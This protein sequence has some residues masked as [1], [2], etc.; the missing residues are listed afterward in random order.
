MA[1][2]ISRRQLLIASSIAGLGLS[3]AACTPGSSSGPAPTRSPGAQGTGDPARRGSSTTPLT[4]SGELKESPLLAEQ[5]AAGQLPPVAERVPANPYVVP[6]NWLDE[7]NYGGTIQYSLISGDGSVPPGVA[8]LFY[9]HSMLRYLNDANDIGPGLVESWEV[10]ADATVWTFHLRPGLRW[11]DGAPATTEDIM[12]WWEDLVLNEEHPDS[13]PDETKSSRGTTGTIET[14]SATTFTI[15]FDAP[16]PLTADRMAM[17]TNGPGGQGAMWICP[18]HYLQQFHRT[19]NPAVGAN[20]GLAE[21]LFAQK[22]DLKSNPELPTLN[23]FKVASVQQGQSMVWERNPYY[24]AIT[25]QG[26]QLPFVDR[27]QMTLFQD[28]AVAK[29]Q[30][31]QGKFD[32]GHDHVLANAAQLFE[33][34][35][36]VELE[37]Y[38]WDTGSGTGT[39]IFHN[40]DYEEPKMRR[41]INEP[42]YRQALSLAYNRPEAH[43]ALY[44]EQGTITSG[45]MSPKA[46]EFNADDAGRKSLTEWQDSF[47]D[48][49]P[50]RAKQLL[51]EVGV[52]EGPD[53]VRTMPDG[54]PLEIVIT[55]QTSANEQDNQMTAM[56]I[57]DWKAIGLQARTNPVAPDGI[58]E[59]WAAG[60]YALRSN[61]A[62]GDGPN[63]LIYPQWLVPVDNSRWAPMQ[64]EWYN[65]RG[66]ALETEGLDAD[67]YLRQPPR[68]EPVPDGPVARLWDLYDQA[69][70]EPDPVKRAGHV[71]QMDK[72]HATEGPFFQGTV[73][74]YPSLVIKRKGLRNVPTRENLALGGYSSPW[75]HPNPA[76]YDPETYFWDDPSQHQ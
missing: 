27:W 63:H 49:D 35:D 67:P 48:Y 10:N 57:R 12:F 37:V 58:V 38:M 19:Y 11:S 40:L 5:V 43:K 16:A 23:G 14:V 50:E 62:C 55:H 75:I 15:T 7:G 44:F 1:G 59:A 32:Y 73:A 30:T 60:K 74:N 8:Q 69:R 20:W 53:G 68:V 9:G 28:E 54:S 39:T 18:K 66:T 26:H 46:A 13:A 29:L 17:W 52:T 31:Q 33:I 36:S 24:W 25:K 71:L 45:T 70:S 2:D 41:L 3:F 64:G 56:L 76:V 72:I 61:W 6:H 65:S 42:K 51:D 47:S 21:G 22:A 4:F 34:A